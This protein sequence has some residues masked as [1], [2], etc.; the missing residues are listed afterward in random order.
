MPLSCTTRANQIVDI[1]GWYLSDSWTN[2]LK[3]QIPAG[4]TLGPGQYAVFDE[5]DFNPTPAN[6]R[7]ND[8]ALNGSSGDDVWLVVADEA[9]NVIS[10]VD[11]VHFGASR[12][13]ES[14][15]RT[16]VNR[17]APSL[18][19]TLG[20]ANS[21]PRVGPIVFSELHYNPGSIAAAAQ[22]LEPNLSVDDLEF[23]E[24][25]NPTT[26]DVDLTHWLISGGISYE[27]AAG[28]SLTAGESLVIV[29]FDP[30]S[31]GNAGRLAAF[32]V[33]HA[34]DE[35]IRL[36]GGYSGALSNRGEPVQVAPSRRAATGSTGYDSA[37]AGR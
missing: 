15:Q 13:G 3:Y 17:L 28:T 20:A 18:V 32:R 11:D 12:T 19:V 27:F 4:I 30:T 9:G 23:L 1:G 36:V 16:S 25:H 33:H 8:F 5:S 35:S 24:I 6:P 31:A 14:F 10:F 7:P 29:P 34:L 21:P 26:I 37:V 22:L 2:L